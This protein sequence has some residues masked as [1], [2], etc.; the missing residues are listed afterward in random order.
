MRRTRIA[1]AITVMDKERPVS[2]RN[3]SHVAIATSQGTKHRIV[4]TRTVAV[5][6][7]VFPA[8][9]SNHQSHTGLQ[10]LDMDQ[11]RWDRVQN[12]FDIVEAKDCHNLREVCWKKL[13]GK[14]LGCRIASE[15]E[16][17]RTRQNMTQNKQRTEMNESS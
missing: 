11:D 15:T 6:M 8:N 9:H 5:M 14:Q 12:E 7:T 4:R 16:Q 1:W 13:C 3:R 10:H 17:R 2:C